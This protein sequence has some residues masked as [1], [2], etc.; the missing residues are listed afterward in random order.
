LQNIPV[1]SSGSV[2]I[3]M[4]AMPV[5]GAVLFTFVTEVNGIPYEF[6]I[7]DELSICYECGAAQ[8]YF[9]AP[10]AFLEEGFEVHAYAD[11]G[12]HTENNDLARYMHVGMH[13]MYDGFDSNF[14]SDEVGTCL[15][16]QESNTLTPISNSRGGNIT[17]EFTQSDNFFEF[18]LFNIEEG[19]TLFVFSSNG[20]VVS[21]PVESGINEIQNI[22]V[23]EPDTEMVTIQ[24]DGPGAVCGIK[25]CIMGTRPPSPGNNNPPVH[26]P[27]ERPKT[28]SPTISP[29]P[30]S[31]PSDA[32][33]RTFSPSSAPTSAPTSSPSDAPSSAPT[34]CY[35]RYGISITEDDIISQNDYA[36]PMPEDSVTKI[37]GDGATVTIEI[38]QLWSNDTNIS[39]F[40]QYH[41]D[42]HDTV[43]EGVEDF[44]YEA[45]ITK[46]ME[47]YDGWTDVGI[48]IYFEEGL[49]IDECDACKP[50]A[51][52]DDDV[53][54]Y[55]FEL[56][57]EPICEDLGSTEPP[58]PSPPKICVD[59]EEQLIETVPPEELVPEDAIKIIEGEDTNVVIE[60]SQL[61]SNDTNVSF[62]IQYHPE[63]HESACE[64]IEDFSYEDTL[65][66][67]LECFNGWTDMG[68]FVYFD[69]A[70]EVD[71]CQECKRPED[72]DE[73]V[74][75]YYFEI[76]CKPLC[77]TPAPSAAPST[78]PSAAPTDC[79]DR[80]DASNVT[81]SFPTEDEPVPENAFKV[82]NGED[83]TVTIEI[84][85]LWTTE[86]DAA[87]F[88][89]YH[90]IG[91]GSVCEHI[92]DFSYEASIEKNLECYDGWTD[93]GFFMYFEEGLVF[94]ECEG[95]KAPDSED[96][97]IVAYYFEI[98]C[99][100]VC[101][102]Y[103]L[104]PS[105]APSLSKPEPSMNPDTK[106][107]A[108]EEP[109]TE[110]PA[111]EEPATKQPATEE[112]STEVPA[113][114]EPSTEVPAVD[115]ACDADDAAIG[116]WKCGDDVYVCPGITEVCQNQGSKNSKYYSISE[117]QCEAMKSK[118]I[119]DKC[120]LL[121]QYGITSYNGLGLSNRV[122]YGSGGASK[123]ESGKCEECSKFV[124]PDWESEVYC[125]DGIFVTKDEGCESAMPFT[126]EEL[127][128]SEVRFS[129][130][131][132]WSSELDIELFYDKGNGEKESQSLNMLTSDTMYAMTLSAACFDGKAEI[133]V[134]TSG[135]GSSCSYVYQIPCSADVTI[136]GDSN[137]NR[138][139]DDSIITNEKMDEYEDTPYCSHKDY[140]CNGDEKN[141]VYVC[142]YSSR[143]GYQT[144]CMPEM[145][146]DVI[147]FN[148]NHH[149]GPCD[150]WN[151]V[152]NAGQVS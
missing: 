115:C 147:R 52:E 66:Y 84:S 35:D 36:E 116:S 107:P 146:S 119:G 62:F 111:V 149:C 7:E 15:I 32:P 98:S 86:V 140:P 80:L 19:A 71:E 142:H 136:C 79:Y 81:L 126:V 77:E 135:G 60:L 12:A 90:T 11:D 152:E 14:I 3:P 64:G 6:T 141:M 61:W 103:L 10:E 69:G 44:E 97:N 65:T 92:P 45:S 117:S 24:F 132:K 25:A 89:Q 88:V 151:G 16:I 93:L 150:G 118:E 59:E 131:N 73:S 138:K 31:S 4:D 17:F 20:S 18:Q 1:P 75:A 70:M 134:S 129:F 133:E 63:T 67:T 114:E 30:S 120:V 27:T 48:F 128:E 109:N 41:N 68:L 23:T 74:V 40:V 58:D 123:T 99:E 78:A 29:A 95:C 130:T 148:K 50:P 113:V 101:D 72:D 102:D 144:F 125:D 26:S 87:A 55:Y 53:F 106:Q 91:H 54:A 83:T 57:C 82:I 21:I 5:E 122:C 47:C 2:S 112:P 46:D 42:I 96:E 51:P 139:L 34:D 38:F 28:P 108:T 110:V 143:A 137:T 85:Q 39:F 49:T 124:E 94:D 56:P 43:C 8:A 127:D 76:P 100:P 13:D 104:S 33:T 37:D 105:A 121:E 145:D 9:A 22:A